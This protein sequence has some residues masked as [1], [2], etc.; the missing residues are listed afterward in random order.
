MKYLVILLAFLAGCVIN[1]Q[2]VKAIPNYEA[3]VISV[4][5]GRVEAGVGTI[6]VPVDYKIGGFS[7]VPNV[8]Q[9][10]CYAI[11]EHR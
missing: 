7:C 10:K 4:D 6:T 11:I 3:R 2:P 5:T 9:A 1:T 8:G